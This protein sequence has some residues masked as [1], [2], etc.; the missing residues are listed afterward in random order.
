MLGLYACGGRAE[1]I[2]PA[3]VDEDK[4]S[5]LLGI[6]HTMGNDAN[7]GGQ[8]DVRLELR[9]DGGLRVVV[10]QAGGVSLSFPGTW[11]LAHE[12][13]TDLLQLRGAWFEPDGAIDV[14]C[15]IRDDLLILTAADGN[16]QTWQRVADDA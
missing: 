5:A 3:P 10:T 1:G 6:W 15:Q 9:Q 8:V 12:S 14:R 13:D 16:S 4:S 7:L 11:S 2:A